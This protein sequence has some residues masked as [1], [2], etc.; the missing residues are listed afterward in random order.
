M[1]ISIFSC[2]AV[3]ASAARLY[4]ESFM[5]G[6]WKAPPNPL[7]ETA[8]YA[9]LFVTMISVLANILVYR[10]VPAQTITVKVPDTTITVSRCLTPKKSV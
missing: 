4:A 8:S 6:R 10:K 2:N 5:H 1:G 3:R 7:V 9:L